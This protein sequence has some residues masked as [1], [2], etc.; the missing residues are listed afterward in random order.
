MG[1]LL[2][3]SIVE[4][5]GKLHLLW[6]AARCLGPQGDSQMRRLVWQP[7]GGVVLVRASMCPMMTK[8]AQGSEHTRKPGVVRLMKI[9]SGKRLA[10]KSQQLGYDS[11]GGGDKIAM[12]SGPCKETAGLRLT[13]K[14]RTIKI[15]I[16]NLMSRSDLSF[17]ANPPPPPGTLPSTVSW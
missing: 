16:Y 12:G 10:R 4:L 14:K 6:V 15:N 5:R 13:H 2:K 3:L 17:S 1:L 8:E 9:R 7:R 11:G